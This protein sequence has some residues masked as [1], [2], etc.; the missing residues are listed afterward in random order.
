M[1]EEID[2]S[3]VRITEEGRKLVEN[4]IKDC[5]FCERQPMVQTQKGTGRY[6]IMCDP[7]QSHYAY[8]NYMS[9]E[10]RSMERAV[11][12]WNRR[13]DR[14]NRWMERRARWEERHTWER[15]R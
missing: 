8:C 3:R 11:R 5:P 10:A 1:T 6:R 15:V 14:E 13:V 12:K 4:G 2:M 7:Y 9:A